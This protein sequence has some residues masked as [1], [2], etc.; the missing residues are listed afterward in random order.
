MSRRSPKTGFT[1]GDSRLTDQSLALVK[2]SFLLADVDNNARLSGNTFALPPAC[3]GSAGI[4]AGL[5]RFWVLFATAN[6]QRHEQRGCDSQQSGVI[7]K[8]ADIIQ[9]GFTHSTLKATLTGWRV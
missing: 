3:G 1:G 9:R 7:H 4:H 2:V 5:I 6:N 8:A